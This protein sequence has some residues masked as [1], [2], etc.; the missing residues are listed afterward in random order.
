V[1][2]RLITLGFLL[3]ALFLAGVLFFNSCGSD[4][5]ENTAGSNT[6][7]EEA[8]TA[9]NLDLAMQ[10]ITTMP[11]S[12]DNEN[13]GRA[14]YYLN[15]WLSQLEQPAQK[16][17]PDPLLA[18][19]PR[20]YVDVSPLKTLERR[21]FESTDLFYLQECL[22]FR[23]IARRVAPRPAPA[24]LESWLAVL[25]KKIGI[26]EAERVRSAERL[27]D[28]TICNIQLD[29]LPPPPKAAAAGVGK[30][31][32]TSLPAPIRGEKGPGYWQLPWQSLLYGHG[33]SWQRS[34]IFILM[35]R[36]A[37]ITAHMLG[38]QDES[39]SGAVRPWLCAA[40]IK[41][42][43]YLFDAELGFP[44]LG[45]EGR[46]IATL[47][48]VIADPG[49]LRTLDVPGESPYPVTNS[50]LNGIQVL[51]DVEPESLALRM[52][53]LESVL[54][55]NN[56]VVLYCRPSAEE[57]EIRKCKHIK[58]VSIWR[59]GLEALLF[60]GAQADMRQRNPALQSA[61][62]KETYMFFP[63]NPLAEGRHLEFEGEFDAKGEERKKGACQVFGQLR[64]PNATIESLDSSSMAR[65]MLGMPDAAL[66]KDPKIRQRQI[67]D[68]MA[69]S[70]KAKN[71]ATYWIG[72]CHFDAGDYAAAEEWFRDRTLGGNQD[73]PWLHGARYNLARCYEAQG[74]W[75]Q[76]RE[77]YIADESPQKI[78]NLLRAQRIAGRK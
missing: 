70:R 2:S 45:P 30:F 32:P 78:G 62:Y 3:T 72:L 12:K 77:L 20:S 27:F 11:V 73:S 76:A 66:S 65:T 74:K 50:E 1:N 36:Q 37:G 31:D 63:P 51:I 23:D 43:L 40:L 69:I 42:Q 26:S 29:K 16:F 14:L 68:L 41:D 59:I 75:D 19:T 9:N 67:E 53:L 5:R 15:E 58:D 54:I 18:R 8:Q 35:C 25:E 38:V 17:V 64:I 49:L 57:K 52:Q 28:W 6:P 24:E 60:Q 55:G 46:G 61:H 39:G 33:D 10:A 22:W 47:E 21:R 34:R 13:P 4:P 71:H 48:Q 44:I 56:R 7:R